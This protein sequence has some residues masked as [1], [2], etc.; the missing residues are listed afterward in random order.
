MLLG[1]NEKMNEMLTNIEAEQALLGSILLEPDLI[2]ECVLSEREF[3]VKNHRSIFR[4]MRTVVQKGRKVDFV[5]VVTE[6]GDSINEVGNVTYM[7]QLA[8]SVPSIESFSTY[9]TAILEAFRL[10]RAREIATSL[11]LSTTEEKITEVYKELSDLLEIGIPQ[12]RS[13][14]DLLLEIYEEINTPREEISGIDTGLKDL[15]D[16]TGGLQNGDLIIIAARPSMGKTAFALNLAIQNSINGGVT[17][18]FSLEMSD[19]Q[20]SYRL[21]S[22]IGRIDGSKW[23]SPYKT[24][25]EKD[26]QSFANAVT[27]L[28]DCRIN[29]YDKP[30]Q[31]VF[32]IRT[33]IRKTMKAYPDRNHLVVI[34][35][36]QLIT[37]VT[38]Y[39]RH[40]L[41]IGHITRELK[42]MAREFN[43]PIVLLSQLSRAVEQ[44]NDKRP[45]MSDIRDSG[46]VEQDA[47]I[48]MF[49]YRDDYY[50]KDSSLNDIVEIILSKH[51]NGP[52]GTVAFHFVKEYGLFLNINQDKGLYV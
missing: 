26:H 35:Y 46:A 11:A 5:T 27:V 51:R 15:N 8:E 16:M 25:S 9:Q 44:R 34:D 50:N 6:L 18:I 48:I 52:I 2:T 49:M 14:N 38:K 47:D 4:A 29:M 43:V 10:R 32:D 42:N 23:R 1:R 41:A 12:Q 17:D 19:K 22:M 39:E 3:G 21:L 33:A 13:N 36:L 31:T 37:S 24:F 45:I 7:S 40:D 30:G 20:L 28:E